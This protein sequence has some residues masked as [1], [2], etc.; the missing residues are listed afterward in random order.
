M[1]TKIPFQGY[2]P[3]EINSIGLPFVVAKH[4]PITSL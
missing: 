4:F 3:K 2:M 1:N